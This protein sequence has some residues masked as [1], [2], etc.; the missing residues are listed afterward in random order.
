MRWPSR[1]ALLLSGVLVVG[2]SMG[3]SVLAATDSDG[4]GLRD[5]FES[6][7]GATDP[8]DRDSDRDGVL[9]PA[10]DHDGDGLSD[11]GEQRFG[12]D[13]TDR[14]TDGD[15]RSDGREDRDRD[16]RSDTQE[17]DR[18]PVPSGLRPRLARAFDDRPASYDAGCHNVAADER[19]HP[20]VYG[21]RDGPV[22]ITLYGDSHA[23]QWLPALVRAGASRGWRITTLT[24]SACPS[25]HVRF[26]HSG[27]LGDYAHCRRW[28][29]RAERWIA[30]HDQDLVIVANWEGYRLVGPNGRALS[31]AAAED[32]WR[33]GVAAGLRAVPRGTDVLVLG[34]IPTPGRDVPTCL[35][36][37]RTD[38]SAC[39]RSRTASSRG[40]RE[41]ANRRA[42][43]A[44]GATFRSPVR[45]VC[46]YTP[47]PVVVDHL[48]LWRDGK[49]LT[50]TYARVL[51]PA[52]RR[53]V[54]AAMGS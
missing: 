23:A 29:Q 45:V 43:S 3:G 17:Q 47:C 6:R 42:A 39:V 54:Q 19:L 46:P 5:A 9:D 53:W 13:P 44:H 33:R 49:H 1:A 48:L 50:A 24:K 22:R 12:T 21:D 52:M 51:A 31:R 26:D 41:R 16:G 15:G 20:C 38:I 36:S 37:H 2:A 27:Y 10:E 30:S 18:R 35:R 4:D 32:A 40:L 7:W 14:D 25:A 11:L 28:R 8:G 34:D